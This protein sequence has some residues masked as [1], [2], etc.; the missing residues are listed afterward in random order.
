VLYRFAEKA[1]LESVEAV[2]L[3]TCATPESGGGGGSSSS[4]SSTADNSN[5]VVVAKGVFVELDPT[6]TATAGSSSATY[7]ATVESGPVTLSCAENILKFYIAIIQRYTSP[8]SLTV[9]RT[10]KGVAT[11]LKHVSRSSVSSAWHH[12][13]AGRYVVPCMCVCMHACMRLCPASIFI[14]TLHA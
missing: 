11:H 9:S 12:R 1:L 8:D 13:V 10:Y 7:A 2:F 14:I 3:F 5:I 4:S 6:A